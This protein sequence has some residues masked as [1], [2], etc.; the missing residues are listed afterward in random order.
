MLLN[1]PFYFFL[2]NYYG[3][4]VVVV[5]GAAV[6]VVEAELIN[7]KY[8]PMIPNATIP[9][10]ANDETSV[11]VAKLTPKTGVQYNGT[12]GAGNN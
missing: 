3:A 1:L 11:L 9:L 2:F 6:V 12:S 7:C 5:V 10:A 8:F 4:V